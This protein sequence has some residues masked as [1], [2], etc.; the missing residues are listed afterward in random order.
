M[1]FLITKVVC[2][3]FPKM[4]AT[5]SPISPFYNATKRWHLCPFCLEYGQADDVYPIEVAEVTSCKFQ[6]QTRKG[7]AA[8]ASL[9]VPVTLGALS[10]QVR[11]PTIWRPPCWGGATPH[12]EATGWRSSGWI[13]SS[14]PSG[15]WIRHV[16]EGDFRWFQ[17]LAVG[18]PLVSKPSQQE[19]EVT[20]REA[21]MSCCLR[22]NEAETSRPCSNLSKF[23]THRT[24]QRSQVTSCF[25]P[26]SSQ[27]S[28][29][30]Q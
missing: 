16:S 26:L 3:C 1:F 13:Q 5:M 2:V 6:G 29:M 25:M 10:C 21:D 22:H 27:R 17:L 28:V 18:S 7:H 24:C 19:T 15:P 4:A 23:L 14:D 12:G 20:T 9:T 30:Q 8:S 11:S